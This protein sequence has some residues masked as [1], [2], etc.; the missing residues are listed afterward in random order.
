MDLDD[1]AALATDSSDEPGEA[2][3]SQP[4]ASASGSLAQPAGRGEAA[5]ARAKF[6]P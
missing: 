2:E 1:V 4:A 6:A 5:A 3:D